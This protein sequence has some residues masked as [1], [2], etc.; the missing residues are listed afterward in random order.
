MINRGERER[1]REERRE[2]EKIER[3]RRREKQ[4]SDRETEGG[5][6]RKREKN[7]ERER[8]VFLVF[9]RNRKKLRHDLCF[10]ARYMLLRRTLHECS[11]LWDQTITK[12]FQP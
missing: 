5:G 7:K 3:K 8:R 2:K 9:S 11:V 10:F 4:K 1:D 12:I 6:E